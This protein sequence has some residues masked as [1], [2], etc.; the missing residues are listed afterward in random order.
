[1]PNEH[2]RAELHAVIEQVGQQFRTI[3][4]IQR[5][6]ADLT[7]SATVRKR[8]TVTVNADGMVI[9]TKFAG[10][11]AD[12]EYSEIARAVTEAAQQAGAEVARKVQA[13]ME[14]L[15]DQRARMPKLTDLIEGIPEFAA[16]PPGPVPAS[17]APPSAPE[18]AVREGAAA[19]EFDDVEVARPEGTRDR[20]VTDSGW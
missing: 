12:L 15:N 6:R 19:M 16:N 20:G 2:T 14:P 3:A 1:M 5:D 7:A 8:V 11:I 10:T 17:T 4:Q 18:R 13:L 9:E